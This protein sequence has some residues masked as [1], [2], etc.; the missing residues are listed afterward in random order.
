MAEGAIGFVD[1]GAEGVGRNFTVDEGRKNRE[2]DVLV[3]LAA[4]GADFFPGKLRPFPRNVEAAVARQTCQKRVAEAK[5]GGVA[6]R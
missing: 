1:H 3:A 6:P 2:G 4:K 5:G